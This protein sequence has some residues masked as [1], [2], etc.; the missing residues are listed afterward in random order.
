MLTPRSSRAAPLL[1][2]LSAAGL[3]ATG[4]YAQKAV[5][6]YRGT[7]LTGAQLATLFRTPQCLEGYRPGQSGPLR[8]LDAPQVQE[9][10]PTYTVEPVKISSDG[11][12][13]N[14]WLYLPEQPGRRP[15]VV[16][17]NG[18]GNNVKSIKSF[19][20]F[21]APV[22]AHCGIAAF[23]HDKRGTGDSQG[24]YRETT[25][26]D[27]IRDAGNAAAFLSRHVRV[28]P[29][30]IG[31]M[32][33]SEGGRIAVL[34]ASRYP[35]VAFAVSFAGPVVGMVE[36]RLYAQLNGLAD[37]G[38]ASPQL[39]GE[40]T[41]LW[42]KSLAA[43]ASR[44]QRALEEVDRNIPEWRKRYS[45]TVVPFPTRDL[46]TRPELERLRPTWRSLSSDYMTELGRF[47]K[48]WF[49]MFGAIDRTVPTEAS[50]KNI[51]RYMA[52]SGNRDF[53]VAVIPRCGHTPVDGETGERV[54]FE[55]LTL[56]WISE[57]VVA[58]PR[59][60]PVRAPSF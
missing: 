13:I 50:V 58:L 21:M 11:L 16:L 47:R 57:N 30:L 17:T 4:G 23:V 1:L 2:A 60:A 24:V 12:L 59:R 14:G 55:N 45:W 37:G 32:G 19:S 34:V 33:A 26:D 28:D 10:T 18:G 48:K 9:P 41:P 51:L 8:R 20:D 7:V 15:L 25:Y 54:R 6:D 27:Y 29:A 5:P 56:N 53:A 38:A 49:A 31:V 3:L 44:D 35:Q 36:D 42:E 39:I 40:I 52:L 22:L 46:D 43:W